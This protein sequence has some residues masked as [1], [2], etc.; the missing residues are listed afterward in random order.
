VLDDDCSGGGGGGRDPAGRDTAPV[1]DAASSRLCST[2]PG[3]TCG[4]IECISFENESKACLELWSG[5][6]FACQKM[7]D[8]TCMYA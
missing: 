8:F 6:V 2:S 7:N 3:V 5:F 4:S 1:A